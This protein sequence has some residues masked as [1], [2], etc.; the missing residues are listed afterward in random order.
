M[1][2]E[3]ER[4][5]GSGGGNPT[6]QVVVGSVAADA[7]AGPHHLVVPPS[8]DAEA[9]RLSTNIATR[10]ERFRL[11]KDLHGLLAGLVGRMVWITVEDLGPEVPPSTL[12]RFG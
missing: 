12:D 4:R 9:F 6:V 3:S 2:R 1:P 5:R 7:G 8:D 11:C 10:P